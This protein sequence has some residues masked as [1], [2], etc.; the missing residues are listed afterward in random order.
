M[1]AVT[2]ALPAES[3][4]F[5]KLLQNPIRGRVGAAEFTCASVAGN[6]VCV[7]H[8]GV[9]AKIARPRVEQLL[10]HQPAEMLISCGFAGAL[11]D[12]LQPG[13]L[14]LADNF[15]ASPLLAVAREAL[16]H[17]A[18]LGALASAGVVVDSA[19]ARAA[20]AKR[21]GAIAV[22]METEVIAHACHTGHVPML[23]LR[24]ITDTP[25][26]PLPAPPDVLFDVA[27]QQTSFAA[28]AS[29]MARHPASL[30]KLGVFARRV[31]FVRRAVTAALITLLENHSAAVRA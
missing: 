11:G 20:L 28:L 2:F 7:L 25:Q 21:T 14:L 5:L 3:S 13:D 6:R 27:R 18:R 9:G 29:H 4:D 31:A 17:R 16:G 10:A 30:W 8:T 26:A 23:S 12:E 19:L 1:I 24:G 15:S 22:D